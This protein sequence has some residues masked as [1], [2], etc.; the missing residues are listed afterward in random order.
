MGHSVPQPDN[1][2]FAGSA[3][4]QRLAPKPQMEPAMPSDNRARTLRARGNHHEMLKNTAEE[5]SMERRMGRH[6]SRRL[7]CSPPD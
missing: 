2:V 1:R 7:D 6:E 5:N 3:H 4:F